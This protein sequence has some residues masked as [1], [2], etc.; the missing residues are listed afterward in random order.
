[1]PRARATAFEDAVKLLAARERTRAQV[2]QALARRGHEPEAIEAALRRAHELRYLDDGRVA[3]RR[4]RAELTQGRARADVARRLEAVG[5]SPQV[6]RAAVDAEVR[7]SGHDEAAAARALLARRKVTGAKA[8]RLLL[9]R[10]FD[11]ELVRRLVPLVD[12]V[13]ED[14]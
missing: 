6:A 3:A 5:V 10:G 8:A 9:S 13:G 4:A 11:E 1:M 2:A 12:G 7:E 14:G